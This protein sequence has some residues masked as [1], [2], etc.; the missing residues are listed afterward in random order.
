MEHANPAAIIFIL[1]IVGPVLLFIRR[2][3]KGADIFIRRIP[4]IDAIDEAVGRS[5]ELGRPMSF[6]TG[7]SSLSPA[8]YA[9]LNVLKHIARKAALY[10]SK[11]FFPCYDPEV[12]IVGDAVIQNA[13]RTER[14]F[15]KYDPSN[16]RFLSSDQFAYASGYMGLIDREN[17]SSAFLFGSFAAESLILAEAGQRVGAVQVAATT[18]NEQIPF[19]ITACDYTLIGEELYAAGAFLSEDPVQRGSIRGQDIAKLAIAICL[20]IGICQATFSS[21]FS[22]ETKD[23]AIELEKKA[24]GQQSDT[25]LERWLD[26]DWGDLAAF[27][28]LGKT[29]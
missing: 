27:C 23:A 3:K 4:G 25:M 22:M 20:I 14:K 29:K 18:S 24:A 9:S 19:F 6:T 5:V 15:S 11:L 28:G 26:A 17:V 1:L 13:Y 8:V 16:I 21:C 7:L 2:A 12:M 10:G